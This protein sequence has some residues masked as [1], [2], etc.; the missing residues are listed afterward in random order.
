MVPD[1]DAWIE[2]R[3]SHGL[4]R[5][6]GV[7][8]LWSHRE[9]G[10][11]FASRELKLRYKQ[12]VLGVVWVLL[13]PLLMMVLFS[14][15]FER[16][17]GVP[18]D[19]VPYPLFA[20][21]GLA[22]WTALA[23]AVA[24][25]GE[26]LT[27]DPS[28][29]TKVYFP[30]LLVPAGAVLPAVVDAGI[31]LLLAGVLM[32]TYGV[33]PPV[34]IVLLP[35][36]LAGLVTVAFAVGVLLAALNV[37]YRDVRYAMGFGLQAWLFASPV[38]FPASLVPEDVRALFYLNPAAGLLAAFRAVLLGTPVFAL[39]MAISLATLLALTVIAI[40]YFRRVERSFADRI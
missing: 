35:V 37:L 26:S 13:Q 1:S 25:A 3:P 8:E 10:V 15:L 28:L 4:W 40:A 32:A 12:T 17:V 18:S 11:F 24:R 27:D 14:V 5:G 29:V 21:V 31:A 23:T 20:F 19:G 30:R 2:N 33:T 9:L 22:V 36:C 39:G 34:A 38:L 6:I 16:V 7:G